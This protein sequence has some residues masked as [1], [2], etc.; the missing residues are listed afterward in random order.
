MVETLTPETFGIVAVTYAR[1]PCATVRR[2][3]STTPLGFRIL[4]TRR[5][6]PEPS[7]N[8]RLVLVTG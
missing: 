3:S 6:L 4:N 1:I 8:A 5:A 7:W 2:V